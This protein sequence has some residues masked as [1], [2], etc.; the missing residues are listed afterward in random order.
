MIM[1]RYGSIL[2]MLVE[3]SNFDPVIF[4]LIWFIKSVKEKNGDDTLLKD[5]YN[6][7]CR[8]NSIFVKNQ[9]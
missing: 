8:K 6:T 4:E 9:Q 7:I 5:L 1:T 3:S 2:D